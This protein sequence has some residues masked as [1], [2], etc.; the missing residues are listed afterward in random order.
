MRNQRVLEQSQ[1]DFNVHNANEHATQRRF[2]YVHRWQL[3]GLVIWDNRA[4]MYRAR[5]FD[6]NQVR[7]MYRTT[8]AD[9]APSLPPS[10]PPPL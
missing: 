3:H 4:V 2:V 7:D 5:P 9:S 6:R 1:V 10:L 8:V